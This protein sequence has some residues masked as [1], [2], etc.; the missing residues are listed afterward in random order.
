MAFKAIILQVTKENDE[1][2]VE[3]EFTDGKTSFTKEYPFIHVNDLNTVFDATMQSE[4]KRV[5]D[6]E[7]GYSE[8][9]ARENEEIILSGM[10]GGGH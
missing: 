4:L 9:K 8:L 2:K 3:I 1:V 10:E 6:L 5:N 7:T